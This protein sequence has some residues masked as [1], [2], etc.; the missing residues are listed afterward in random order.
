MRGQ[1]EPAVSDMVPN[2][3]YASKTLRPRPYDPA[4]ARA[5]LVQDGFTL[6]TGGYL[7]KQGRRLEVPLWT[8]S[9]RASFVQTMQLIAQSWR[10]AS[11]RKRTR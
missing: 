2:G 9:G 4:R 11:I 5:L 7:Y 10:P 1:A 8:L 3:A 6:G